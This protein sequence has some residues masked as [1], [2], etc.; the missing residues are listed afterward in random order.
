MKLSI[1]TATFNAIEKIPTLLNSL[2]AQTDKEFEWVVVDGASTDGTVDLLNSIID[3]NITVISEEDFGIYD[4]LNKAIKICRGEFYLVVGADD[5]LSPMA[6]SI[7]KNNI[8]KSVDIVTAHVEIDGSILKKSKRP[9]WLAGQFSY[10]TGHSVSTVFRKS[11]HSKFGYYSKKYPIA[12]DQEFIMKACGGGA[13]LKSIDSVVGTFSTL[14]VSSQDVLG[15]LTESCRIKIALGHN[16][17]MQVLILLMRI[18]R[19]RRKI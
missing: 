15:S 2:R 13:R 19:Y 6:V 11:L 9:P 3:L 12:A 8:D 4:A 14:G 7:F 5:I 10:V 16:K 18:I 17:Y 1:V